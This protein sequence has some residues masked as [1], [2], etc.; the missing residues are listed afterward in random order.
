MS[1]PREISL[2]KWAQELIR[3]Q[4]IRVDT[5]MEPAVEA[6]RKLEACEDRNRKLSDVLN[7][8]H[9]LLF[10]AAKGGHHTS[11]EIVGVLESYEIF[12]P[13]KE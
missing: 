10:T 9:E 3:N 4:R 7:A 1:D 6:R 8:L 5:A 13:V 2:P 11:Q 12:K